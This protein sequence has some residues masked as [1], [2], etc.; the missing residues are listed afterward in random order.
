MAQTRAP[1]YGQI[2]SDYATLLASTP[3]EH[4]GPVWMVNLMRY[5]DRADYGDGDDRGLTG[6]EADDRYA[7]LGPLAAVGAEVVFVADVES[8]LLGDAP[9]WDRVAVV[10]YPTR[11]AFVDLQQR[12]D[13]RRLHLHK[14]AGM[15]E[16]I[17]IGCLP[18]PVPGTPPGVEL[19]DWDQ[20]PHP[21]TDGDGPISVCHVIRFGDAPDTQVMPEDME[22]YQASIAGLAVRHGIRISGW[23]AVEG[24]IVGDGRQWDQVRFNSFP[25]RAAFMA[26][27]NEPDAVRA[28]RRHRDAAIADTYTMILRPRVDRLRESVRRALAYPELVERSA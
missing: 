24:T 3:V 6:R 11:R 1:R 5:R 14:E 21:A 28:R 4:D 2:D 12:G 19:P 27:I 23:F 7:P 25:S 20:V 15:A 10:E 9:R 16:T 22:A 18:I 8:Q 13:F 17:V 26:L